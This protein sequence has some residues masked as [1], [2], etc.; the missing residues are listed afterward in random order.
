MVF[1]SPFYHKISTSMHWV[2]HLWYLILIHDDTYGK[3]IILNIDR[4]LILNIHLYST[5]WIKRITFFK[6]TKIRTC[7]VNKHVFIKVF[8]VHPLC[9]QIKRHVL[10]KCVI[11]CRDWKRLCYVWLNTSHK[12]F[13]ESNINWC[14]KNLCVQSHRK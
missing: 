3:Y 9:L 8:N 11:C 5:Y 2:L 1:V 10:S 14:F 7:L 12:S 13:C 4:L 6:K